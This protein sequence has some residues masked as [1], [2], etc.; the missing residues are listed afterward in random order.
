M[1]NARIL[2]NHW[3][4]VASFYEHIGDMVNLTLAKQHRNAALN[5]MDLIQLFED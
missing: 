1:T 3:D 2:Y 4:S 5:D